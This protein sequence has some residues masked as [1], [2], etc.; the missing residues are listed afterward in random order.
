MGEV[1]TLGMAFY[2]DS[3]CFRCGFRNSC[4]LIHLLIL[5]EKRPSSAV[6]FFHGGGLKPLCTFS[7]I[8]R[9]RKENPVRWPDRS[10]ISKSAFWTKSVFLSETIWQHTLLRKRLK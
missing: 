6:V 2:S 9:V 7:S 4:T 10:R 5:W 8:C 1:D 3:I